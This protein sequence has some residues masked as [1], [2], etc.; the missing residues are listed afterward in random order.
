[1]AVGFAVEVV[2][3]ITSTTAEEPV[4][5]AVPV[6]ST[7]PNGGAGRRQALGFTQMPL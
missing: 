3:S 1:M 2:T 4:G 5:A 7:D 6:F